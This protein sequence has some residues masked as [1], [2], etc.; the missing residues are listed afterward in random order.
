MYTDS[1]DLA[2]GIE[3][4]QKAMGSYYL[5]GYYSS[6]AA[7]DGKYRKISV[8]LNG[9]KYAGV[10]LES[11]QGY[12]AEKNWN[13][14]N[15]QDKEYQLTQALSAGDPVTDL[16]LVLQIDYFRVSPTAY[17]VPVSIRVPGSV[18][19]TAQK[20]G[21]AETQLDFAGQVQDDTHA[22]VGNVRDNIKIRL[23]GANA[24]RAT[25]GTY[26]YD[27]GFTLQPGNYHMKFVVRENITG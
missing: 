3:N 26:Q 25:K 22:A 19:A 16:P 12:Y 24:E 17:Y 11:R 1:N 27:A 18:V 6:N 7:E 8:K 4:V 2:L 20:G 9:N 5:I 13:K 21:A 10:K 14:L 23:D 15:G